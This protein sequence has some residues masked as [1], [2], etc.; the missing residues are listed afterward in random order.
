[1]GRAEFPMITEKPYFL[2]LGPHV[3]LWFSLEPSAPRDGSFEDRTREVLTVQE[4]W[5]ELLQGDSR[6]RT[7]SYLWSY[8]RRRPWFGGKGR[9]FKSLQIQD[10][11]GVPVGSGE[12][13]LLLVQVEY[14]EGDPQRYLL[15][16]SV[17][18]AEAA[19]QIEQRPP[20]ET[21]ARV[22]L[23]Q[24]DTSGVLYNAARSKEFCRSLLEAMARRR[25]FGGADGE[26]KAFGSP[27]LRARA[28]NGQVSLEPSFGT[29]VQ[30]NRGII[31][32]DKYFL[33]L[34]RRVEIGVNPELEVGRFLTASGFPN[35]PAVAGTL[36]YRRENGEETT[37]GV[38]TEF[39]P[40]V[41]DA[42]GY[43]LDLLSRYFDRVRTV[44]AEA[45]V[46]PLSVD[47]VL[48]LSQ[49]ESPESVVGLIGTYTELAR[50]LG[51]RTAE[52]HL[53]LGRD[54]Q[55]R[56]FAPEPFTPFYQ[57]ALFQSMRNLAVRNLDQLRRAMD[58]LPEA[59][60]PEAAQVVASQSDIVKRLR[61]LYEMPLRAKRIRC[62]GDFHLGEVLFTGKDFLFIDFE[63]EPGRPL[64]ERRIKRSPL[65]DVAG[66]IRSFDYIT[67]MA[68]FRQ[69]E[70]GTLHERDLPLLEPW[71]AFWYRWVSVFFLRAYLKA[72]GD[73]D[74]LPQSRD[75]LLLLLEAH[76]FEKALYEVGYELNNRPH[77][78]KI[79]L[80]GLLRIL[81]YK[82]SK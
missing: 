66:M 9:P 20:E 5:E 45:R 47:S 35:I 67:A 15:P 7:E 77:L 36:E 75:Q 6:P 29:A 31:F 8:L 65:R 49:R 50:L 52:M 23:E 41:Q 53:A 57:R 10:A 81:R 73:T 71:G 59:I 27:G 64:G 55:N 40:N 26:L 48:D 78:L 12:D 72:L 17:A 28:I 25:S 46:D 34:F 1:M 74:L 3:A 30:N 14:M 80:R 60:R 37:L 56:D 21:I 63:G 79:P 62:H 42:W 33:K 69:V 16:V 51:Q 13:F 76:L 32:G 70:L 39:Q 58:R 82:E 68:L 61:A 22:R 24:S 54:Q 43:T 4:K 18:I 44:P 19:E 38:L 11:I 2:T